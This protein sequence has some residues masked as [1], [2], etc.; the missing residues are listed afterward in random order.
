MKRVGD[1]MRVEK[2]GVVHGSKIVG[3][4]SIQAASALPG[5]PT[6]PG[7]SARTQTA[8]VKKSTSKSKS[9]NNDNKGKK[10][11]KK[12]W[13]N[14][15]KGHGALVASGEVDSFTL[16]D[17]DIIEAKAGGKGKGNPPV[18][19]VIIYTV[20]KGDGKRMAKLRN[21]LKLLELNFLSCYSYPVHI[22]FESPVDEAMVREIAS[23]VPSAYSVNVQRI[24]FADC[25][26]VTAMDVSKAKASLKKLKYG[27]LG[28]ANMWV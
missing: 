1:G 22:F 5:L 8:A 28:Y 15:I 4:G 13:A 24:C 9:Q 21:S 23:L 7:A 11:G 19:G 6:L 16:T 17:P 3:V 2:P 27:W 26:P 18:A 10:K 12:K 25:T 20:H 14:A